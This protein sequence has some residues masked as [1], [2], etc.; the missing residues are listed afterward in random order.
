M[1]GGSN[2]LRITYI[3]EKKEKEGRNRKGKNPPIFE[4]LLF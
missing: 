1:Q 3:S 2:I 4:A